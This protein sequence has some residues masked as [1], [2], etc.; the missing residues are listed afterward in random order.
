MQLNSAGKLTQMR[1]QLPIM[2]FSSVMSFIAFLPPQPAKFICWATKLVMM[3]RV[4]WRVDS[5]NFWLWG[6]D[7]ARY[8]YNKCS[9]LSNE[10]TKSLTNQITFCHHNAKI[11]ENVAW[12]NNWYPDMK[13]VETTSNSQTKSQLTAVHERLS[14]FLTDLHKQRSAYLDV[15][16]ELYR[17]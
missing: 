15:Y 11:C 16:A 13:T 2:T 8:K 5:V 7:T 6:A 12:N 10:Q 17:T 3:L 4:T 1:G 9:K 14:I